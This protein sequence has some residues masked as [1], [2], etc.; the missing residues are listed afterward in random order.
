MIG[1]AVRTLSPPR[2]ILDRSSSGSAAGD[3]RPSIF[4]V[5]EHVVNDG[6]LDRHYVG[7]L[8]IWDR[9]FGSF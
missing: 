1:T 6:Y 5:K 9:M 3:W 7:I 8:V 4:L 2:Q